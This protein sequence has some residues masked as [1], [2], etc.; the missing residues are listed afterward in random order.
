MVSGFSTASKLVLLLSLIVFRCNLLAQLRTSDSRQEYYEQG[1]KALA[2]NRYADAEI[3]YEKLRQ[4]SPET[5]EVHARLGLVYFQERKYEPAVAS[6]R[7]ALKLKPSLPKLDTLLAMSLSEL[8]RYTE[9][10]PGLQ[11]G[12]RQSSDAAVQRMCGLELTKAYTGLQRDNEAVEV[13]S[14]LRGLYPDDPEILYEA[15]RLYAN[16]SYLALMKLRSVAP[17]SAWMHQAAAETYESQAQYDLAIREYR[18]V[19]ALNPNRPGVH[20]RL[21]RAIQRARQ[22]NWQTEAQMEFQRELQLDPGNANAAYEMGELYRESGDFAQAR[23]F[24]EGALKNFPDFEEAQV[25][26]GRTLIALGKP[27]LA[28]AP[29]QK[30]IALNPEDAIG[31]YQLAL[32]YKAT[33]NTAEQQEAL[34]HFQHLRSRKDEADKTFFLDSPS[35]NAVTKQ[36]FDSAPTP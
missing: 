15:S 7:Q 4:L 25:G 13:A 8:G 18:A 34:A 24:F 3:A 32:A 6:L 16:A 2:E 21:G 9:S 22:A 11:K 12:F 29:L 19:L 5:A 33:G 27:E 26:L 17:T 14:K 31:Y 30:A 20:F 36:E 10:L 23:S 1:E 28:R 35:P